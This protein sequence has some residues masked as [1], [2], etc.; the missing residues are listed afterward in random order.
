M[1]RPRHITRDGYQA[2]DWRDGEGFFITDVWQ[3]FPELV[4]GRYLVNTSYDSGSLTLLGSEREHGWRNVGRL[5]HSPQIHSIDEI[6][7]DQFDEWLVFGQPV[8]V[9]EFETMVNYYGF[10][11]IDFGWDEKRERFW[12][13]V[14]RLQPLHV[15]AENDGV[16]LVSRDEDLIHKIIW[17]AKQAHAA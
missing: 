3:R 1:R 8:Q 17:E 14:I 4:V 11:P 2:I 6:P 15:L 16:Y 13:Q 9:E 5:A 7:H 12:Q 10:T